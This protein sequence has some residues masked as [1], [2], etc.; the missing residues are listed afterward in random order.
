MDCPLPIFGKFPRPVLVILQQLLQNFRC[1]I[2][3]QPWREIED[4]LGL[5]RTA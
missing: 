1:L 4:L 5:P 3:A 2:P